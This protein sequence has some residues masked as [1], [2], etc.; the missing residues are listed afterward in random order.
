MNDKLTPNTIGKLVLKIDELISIITTLTTNI[1]KLEEKL[2][3]KENKIEKLELVIKTQNEKI[4]KQ[5][6]SLN[7][8]SRNSSKPPSTDGYKKP[9]PKS[10]RKKS[11]KSVGGQNGHEGN[12]LKL[13]QT[14][15]QRIK[16]IP[17]QCEGCEKLGKCKACTI[18]KTRYDI[19]IKVETIVTAHEV[20]SFNCPNKNNKVI[21]GNFP[22]NI[23]STMQYGDNLKALAISLNTFGMMS[24]NRTH[25]VLSSVFGVPISTGTIHSMVE[26]L[27]KKATGTVE[28][29]R[30]AIIDL[31]FAHFDETGLRVESKLHWVHSA[32]N[33]KYTYMSAEEKR[34]KKGME[35]SGVLPDFNGIAI[36]DF[37]KSYFNYDIDHA[38]CNAHLLRE[39]TGIIENN[40]DQIWAEDLFQLLIQMKNAKE[41]SLFRGKFEL[42]SVAL[43][44][45][46]K[47]YN[48]I[49]NEA[50]KQNP[51]KPK[52]AGKRGRAKKGK[53][54]A[55]VDRFIKYKGEV[56]LF[57]NNFNIPF[58]NNQAER[59]IRMLK[60]KQKVSG[61]FRTQKGAN[62]FT[63]IMS[64]LSTANKHKIDAFTAIKSALK[65][66]ST[67][68]LFD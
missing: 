62:T 7:K 66:N 53:I 51:I 49:L 45:F 29:I 8:N 18:S 59:D 26:D 14:P 15:D 46:N 6:E 60:V 16:H 34:G 24:Y 22:S 32:S 35:S 33:E 56:C 64:Y 43:K 42:D 10:L 36:H 12:G 23:N 13:M 3:N 50:I 20:L 30:Q 44:Y 39:L 54:R 28:E 63:T 9:S 5:A 17:I 1:N 65:G 38:V 11:G 31:P 25:E 4:K 58:D 41:T 21:T 61:G 48:E 67:E 40:P 19:D 37:W 27:G 68:L 47:K 2:S 52:P 55:L 57:L